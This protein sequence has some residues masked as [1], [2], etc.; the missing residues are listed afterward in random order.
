M[1][2]QFFARFDAIGAEANSLSYAD[3]SLASTSQQLRSVRQ[4][5][6]SAEGARIRNQKEQE[7]RKRKIERCENHWFYSS[8]ALQPSLWCRG[9][10]EGR[11]ER[12]KEKLARDAQ[13]APSLAAKEQALE[14]QIANLE[15][16]QAQLQSAVARLRSLESESEAMFDS[17]VGAAPTP[18]L[19]SLQSSAAQWSQALAGERE[20]ASRLQHALQGCAQARGLYM[21]AIQAMH[22][23]GQTNQSAQLNNILDASEMLEHMQQ[24][25]RDNLMHEAQQ[26]A[27][28][29]ANVL[30]TALSSVPAAATSKYPHLCSGLGQVALPQLQQTGAGT[31]MLE[32]FGGDFGDAVAGSQAGSMINRNLHIL[33]ECERLTARQEGMV[34]ALLHTVRQDVANAGATLQQI[35]G[36]IAS[37]KQSIFRS[38]RA[39]AGVAPAEV[40]VAMGSPVGADAKEQLAAMTVQAV[41]HSNRAPAATPP[42]AYGQPIAVATAIPV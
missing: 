2:K 19:R 3:S 13:S 9:G 37:E 6:S 21:S 25:H 24:D 42:E 20:T 22:A 1:D 31:A 14:S 7:R 12:Q 40:A 38:L 4:A 11:I 29:A 33:G 15:A 16:Q 18:Q 23:A 30:T 26:Q 5:E 39:K 28:M 36:S 41:W 17:A 8:T 10:V 34:N 35:N 27:A 32:I